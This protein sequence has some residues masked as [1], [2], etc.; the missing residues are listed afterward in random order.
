MNKITQFL[1]EVRLELSKVVWPTREQLVTYTLTVIGL[2][3][4]MAVF[5]GLMDSG[6]TYVLQKFVIK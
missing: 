5:L 3:L 1:K 2:T 4:F 6:L